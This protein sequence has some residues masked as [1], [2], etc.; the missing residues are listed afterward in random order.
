MM[1]SCSGLDA[2][3]LVLSARM[4]SMYSYIE[5][6]AQQDVEQSQSQGRVCTSSNDTM[7]NCSGEDAAK[8]A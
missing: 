6:S 4:D 2:P 8:L 7:A 3:E 5:Q 1:A